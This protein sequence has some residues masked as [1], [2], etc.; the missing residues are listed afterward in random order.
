MEIPSRFIEV[1]SSPSLKESGRATTGTLPEV[2]VLGVRF[3][4]L[5]MSK[6]IEILNRF[7]T[8]GKPRQVCLSNAYTVTLSQKDRGLRNLLN[9]ADLVLPDG[10]SIVWG[11]RWIGKHIPQR[12]A[13]PDLMEAL[14]DEAARKNYS[15]FLMGSSPENLNALKEV[16][17]KRWPRLPI[18]GLYSP[19]MCEQLSENEN[20]RIFSEIERTRPQILFV[21]MSCPKQEK[22]IAENLEHLH[23]PLAIGV[24][25]AFDFMS[26]RIPRAP[27]WLQ[28]TG[29][30]WLH[31]LSCEPRRL[32]KRYLLGN[33]VFLSLLLKESL[34]K[35]LFSKTPAH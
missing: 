3:H 22:W 13:G 16:L 34:V 6:I 21:S 33:F 15:I 32:W 19:P 11:S 27:L 25:A 29:F 28:R 7:I 26:G 14:C 10:M 35:R 4:C 24:G 31:R 30:E 20:Q 8:E 2:S 9:R 5:T 1:S 17:L 23:M 18:A 12:I